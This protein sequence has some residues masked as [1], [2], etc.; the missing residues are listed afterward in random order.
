MKEPNVSYI[1]KKFLARYDS[2]NQFVNKTSEEGTKRP[3]NT[4][5]EQQTPLELIAENY[6]ILKKDL[7]DDILDKILECTPAFFER[8]IVTMGYSGYVKDAGEAMGKSGVEGIDG[9]IK[10]DVLGL[11]MI[12]LQAKRWKRILQFQDLIF[13]HLLVVLLVN[14]PQKV[15]L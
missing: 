5:E 9:I 13:K 3:T 1:N 7:Q 10:E 15:S 4:S 2:F 14:R 8:L 6:D 11:E 12:Y